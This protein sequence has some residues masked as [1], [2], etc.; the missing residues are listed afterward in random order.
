MAQ[1]CAFFGTGAGAAKFAKAQTQ[2]G[3]GTPSPTQVYFQIRGRCGLVKGRCPRRAPGRLSGAGQRVPHAQ[4]AAS[5][6]P[7]VCPAGWW[8][9]AGLA[10]RK[11]FFGL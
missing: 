6:V 11:F 1:E 10:S 2:P 3:L 4:R 5:R 9:P 8:E 7:A